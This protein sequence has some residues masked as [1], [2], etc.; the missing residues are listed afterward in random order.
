MARILAALLIAFL[1]SAPARPEQMQATVL[2]PQIT[3]QLLREAVRLSRYP[4]PDTWPEIAVISEENFNKA[5][6]GIEGAIG[7]FSPKQPEYLFLNASMDSGI[8]ATVIVHEFVHYLQFKAGLLPVEGVS[9]ETRRW[10]EQEAHVISYRF[11]VESGGV[12]HPMVLVQMECK[13]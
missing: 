6:G 3:E 8:G 13:K 5:S 12:V 4:M 9:C 2:N 1:L 11:D 10:I 7:F